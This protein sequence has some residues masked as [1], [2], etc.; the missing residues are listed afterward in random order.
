AAESTGAEIPSPAFVD[1]GER[2]DAGHAFA[3]VV[4]R[5]GRVGRDVDEGALA[6]DAGRRLRRV[7]V[8]GRRRVRARQDVEI[9]AVVRDIA[10]LGELARTT[11][12]EIL[13]GR[14]RRHRKV[15]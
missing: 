2:A 10:Q 1:G 6:A 14:G 13:D 4:V 9:L 12:A 3:P 5:I 7:E 11:V 15:G 8:D